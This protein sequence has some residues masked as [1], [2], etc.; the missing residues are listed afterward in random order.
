V[1]NRALTRVRQI[2]A[3]SKTAARHSAAYELG[4]TL[5]AQGRHLEAIEQFESALGERPDDPHVLFALG[6]TARALDMARPAEEFYRRV[7]AQDPGRLEALINLA[8]LLRAE[9]QSEA[10]KALLLPALARDPDSAELWLT[11]GSIYRETGDAERAQSHYREALTR[12]TDYPAALA[13]LA[14]MLSDAGNSA[15]ALELYDRAI[16]REPKNAQA[17]LNRAILHLQAG[18]LKEGWRDYAARVHVPGKVPVAEHKIARWTGGSLKRTRLLVTAEQGIG[19]QLMFAS[20]IPEL[21]ARAAA[22]GGSVVLE[23]EPRLQSLFARSFPGV[24][25]HPWDIDTRGGGMR[26]RYG[27]LKAAGGANAAIEMGSLPKLM[28]GTL[29]SFPK[30]NAFLKPDTMENV[31][32]A[33]FLA[34]AGNGPFIGLCW[35]SGKTGGHRAVQYAPLEAW[36][37]FIARLP[38]TLLS[39]Q[40]DA[41]DAE[42]EALERMSGRTIFVPP[43]LDQKIELDRTA[44]MLSSL[45]AVV[46]APTAV[47]WLAAGAG[48]DTYKILYDNSWTSFGQSYEPFGPTCMCMMPRTRGDWADTFDKTLSL[49][50]ARL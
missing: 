47:S 17:R 5:S 6:N 9:G 38:G 20:M 14:D 22:E 50:T 46:S 36:A 1:L 45:D 40:Y 31:L 48:V 4:L 30:Q 49:I 27:W 42:I 32:W 18:E 37:A 10:A 21:A 16:R 33:G 19:D 13:N 23:C 29:D 12:R 43:G 8:N 7:L 44:A 26:A 41:P 24:T 25:V 28:R 34:S 11:L 3:M 39:V 35:R 15:E 2:G